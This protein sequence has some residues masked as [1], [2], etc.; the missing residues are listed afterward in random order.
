M[1]GHYVMERPDGE[2]F[3]VTIPRFNLR[4]MAN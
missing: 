4:A 2:R 1:G 3:R